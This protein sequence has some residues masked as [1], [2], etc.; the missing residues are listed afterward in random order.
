MKVPFLPAA[1]LERK[2]TVVEHAILIFEMSFVIAGNHRRQLGEIAYHHQLRPGAH[3]AHDGGHRIEKIASQHGYLINNDYICLRDGLSHP[4]A[5][6]AP[7][8][9]KAQLKG[10][11][12]CSAA[13]IERRD[14]C[15][16]AHHNIA[17]L[18]A[19]EAQGFFNHE[20]FA[21]AGPAG[22]KD[23]FPERMASM[24][25]CCSASA[26]ARFSEAFSATWRPPLTGMGMSTN[27]IAGAP[28]A[29]GFR[30]PL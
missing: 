24:A 30:S 10:P 14:A 26:Q 1:P 20:G 17:S 23:V 11:V 25:A 28:R 15:R 2:G 7:L 12:H 16:G 21:A 9:S 29:L 4:K 27:P 22:K 19:Q 6:A 18:F 5:R 8:Y 3:F 13:N